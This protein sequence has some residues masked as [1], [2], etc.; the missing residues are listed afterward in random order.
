[1]FWEELVSSAKQQLGWNLGICKFIKNVLFNFG[2]K[3]LLSYNVLNVV[4]A[5]T[6]SVILAISSYF[7]CKMYVC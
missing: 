6:S 5:F 4:S 2:L 7:L 1:M 3:L